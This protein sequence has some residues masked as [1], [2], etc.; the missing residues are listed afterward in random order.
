MITCTADAALFNTA[1]NATTGQPMAPGTRDQRWQVGTGTATGPA[2]VPSW[3]DAFVPASILPA[4]SASPFDNAG[5]VT[6]N[7]NTLHNGQIDLYFR[8]QFDIDPNVSL[9][10]FVLPMDFY[11]DN[12]VPEV[13]VNGDPQS[14][15][16]DG[17]PQASAAETYLYAGFQEGRQASTELTGFQHGRNE[18]IVRVASNGPAVGFMA[19]IQPTAFCSDFGD[20]PASYGTTIADN[21]PRHSLPG[22]DPD[23][24]TTALMLG[25]QIDVEADGQPSADASGDDATNAADEDGVTAPIVATV[26]DDTTVTVSA[27][28]NSDEAATLAGW[29]D[30]NG[31]GTFDAAELVTVAVPANSGTADYQLTFPA[32]TTTSDTF[33]RFRLFPADVT[34]FEPTGLVTGGEVE[35]YPVTVT[36]RDLSIAKTSTMTEDSRP[37]D[38]VTYTVTATNT[39]SAAYTDANPAVV[40]D[41][42]S[43][44][45][46]DADYNSDADAETS[47]GSAVPAPSF[48]APSFLS[49][50]GPLAVGESVTITYSATLTG[51]G[52]GTVRNVA[53]Q[54]NTPPPSG[55]PTSVPSCD[56]A[57]P[58]GT[59]PVTG[60]A[61]AATEGLLPK[62]TIEK[63]ASVQD[64]PADGE[65]V[66]YTVTVT[67]DGPGVS[68]AA[69][70][71][72]ATDDLSAVLDDATFGEILAPATGASFDADAEELT[73]AGPLGVGESVNISYTVVYDANAGGD[74]ILLNT[75]CVPADESTS[76][77][78]ACDSVQIPGANVHMDK[79]VDPESGTSVAAGQ[80]VTYTLSFENTG[81]AP[82]AVNAVDDLADV[83]DDATL[84]T[85]T[86]QPG[87]SAVQSGDELVITGEVPIG[88][89]LTVTYTVT[90]NAYAEQGDHNLGNVLGLPGG[91][92]PPEGCSTTNN[93]IRHITVE[94][95]ATP[96]DG[97]LP[98]D[99]VE[100]TVI[101]TNDGEGDYTAEVPAAISDDMTDVIDDAAYND[102][103]SVVASDGSNVPA[104]AFGAGILTWS[105]P[106]AA[107][108]TVTIT[109]T[110]TVTNLGD[111]DLVNTVAAQCEEGEICDTPPPPVEILLPHVV[112]S[113]SSDPASGATVVAGGIVTYTLSWTN[114]GQASGPLDATDD[115]SDVLDDAEMT[116]NPVVDAA[117]ADSIDAVFD[118][119]EQTI[120]VTGDIAPGE[121]VTVTYQVT[122]KPD[123]ERG[124]N[125]VGNVLTPDV[126]PYE[127]AV[128]G[129]DPFVP[130]STE[131]KIPEIT[132]TKSVDPAANTSVKAGQELTYT[133]TFTNGGTA[134]GAVNRVD[135]LTHVLDDAEVT[136]APAPSDPALTVSA[137]ENSRFS[138]TGQLQPGQTV[139]VSYTVTVKASAEQG[140]QQ[141]A[142][143]LLNPEDPPP[144]DP[145]CTDGE[146]CTFNPISDVTVTKTADP[147]SG[148]KVKEGQNV[149]YMLTFANTGQGAEAID[150]TDHMAGVLDDADLIKAPTASDDALTA[151]DV[152]GGSF[153][154]SGELAAGQTVTVT[155][156]VKVRAWANQGDH[157]LGNVVSVTGQEPPTECAAESGLCTEHSVEEPS[158]QGPPLAVTGGDLGAGIV[159]GAAG[160]LLL[161]A[162][163]VLLYARRR[164]VAAE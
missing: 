89:T 114:D 19:Q 33:A 133:L 109:Y 117:H 74:N 161:M 121:T 30:L 35:D 100:Y 156:A 159:F 102:D 87:L 131:H 40:F 26:G 91:E 96:T 135:D 88:E 55:P 51:G 29:I 153:T 2:S 82:A 150:Y 118:G 61:C 54:P 104:A 8:I 43:K 122:V 142:N 144:A 148:T 85:I 78:A 18:I 127:C 53:W 32:T 68:T 9:E 119:A 139:T 157:S 37:G 81:Q 50:S 10:G 73:W 71:A 132:D 97:V 47:D 44:V 45:L 59:D 27:T 92:C 123:G 46:D 5:W 108:E 3:Q 101:V 106:L 58:Q 24:N 69:A 126:P 146:D 103:V 42:L 7:N 95:S 129:C 6:Y 134:A 62:L 105:G 112:P 140:D 49:W 52:D 107:G 136:A 4:W 143:F 17:L 115:L 66:T 98:G 21:G 160:L 90:V 163:G 155:Y 12:S 80:Q 77:A 162:G 154:V 60:E 138:I 94:K 149:T 145:V 152:A 93:P 70:P 31:N 130:P 113:K 67:N 56:P 48:L 120:R 137:I 141:V 116:G 41:D 124:D 83:L 15:T 110:V 151:S 22:Y 158:P 72:T 125:I 57:S 11:A 84:G 39:G 65:T 1:Y 79:S 164:R 38:T 34:T 75:A 147:A 76:D 111:H 28:N 13:W 14:D 64:L 99:V 16:Q 23:T 128:D 20:A 86:A 63:V 25:T 36:A